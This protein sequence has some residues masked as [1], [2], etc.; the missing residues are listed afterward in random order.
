MT[1]AEVKTIIEWTLTRAAKEIEGKVPDY[2]F[3]SCAD[4]DKGIDAGIYQALSVVEFLNAEKLTSE[5]I[6]NR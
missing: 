5:F 6:T 3:Y 4:H 1:W 2:P